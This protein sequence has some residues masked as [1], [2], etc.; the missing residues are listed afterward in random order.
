MIVQKPLLSVKLTL[1]EQK[2]KGAQIKIYKGDKAE[3]TAVESWT[4]E[5]GK[6]KD[7]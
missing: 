2:S 5:A 1:V 4:S 6:S 7:L 3:G